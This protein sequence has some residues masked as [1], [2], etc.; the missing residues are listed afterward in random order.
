[1]EIEEMLEARSIVAGV[2]LAELASIS[3]ALLIGLGRGL[4]RSPL[5]MRVLAASEEMQA[6]AGQQHEITTVRPRWSG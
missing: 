1:L 3:G 2:K 4:V 6:L 5:R